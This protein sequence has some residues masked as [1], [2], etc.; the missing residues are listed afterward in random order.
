MNHRSRVIGWAK[1]LRPRIGALAAA[2]LGAACAAPSA[3]TER[4]GV[5]RQPA[6]QTGP[7][8]LSNEFELDHTPFIERGIDCAEV[9]FGTTTYLVT[10]SGPI[11]G[12]PEWRELAFSRFD[13]SGQNL[14]R[15]GVPIAAP[16][17]GFGVGQLR[18]EDPKRHGQALLLRTHVDANRY[19]SRAMSRDDAGLGLVAVL[20]ARTG[21]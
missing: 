18:R 21:A 12:T 5:S 4:V 8:M 11:D 17:L 13:R 2:L 10:H 20:T 1:I 16:S 15:F 6:V 14:N 19:A 7:A 9:A 3:G